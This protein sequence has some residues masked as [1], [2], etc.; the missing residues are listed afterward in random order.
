[1]AD[2]KPIKL[3]TAGKLARAESGDVIPEEHGGTG[4][5]SYAQGDLLVGNG[6]GGRLFKRT[7]T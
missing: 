3:T 1:M 5:S 6:S 7:I 4:E 2:I